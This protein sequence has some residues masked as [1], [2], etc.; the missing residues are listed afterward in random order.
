MANGRP[1]DPDGL[2]CASWFWPLGTVL[3]VEAA[4]TGR[5]VIVVV[6]DK[7]PAPRLVRQGRQIDLSRRAFELLGPLRDGLMLVEVRPYLSRRVDRN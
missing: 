2:T 4:G 7:G 5:R 3:V 6:T 1:F